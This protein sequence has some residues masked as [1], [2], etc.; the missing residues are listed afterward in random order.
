MKKIT[1]VVFV[2]FASA[3]FITT[4]NA[5]DSVMQQAQGVFKPIPKSPPR[6]E[7]IP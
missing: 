3:L 7:K 4:L 5:A 2:I 6:N 1:Y